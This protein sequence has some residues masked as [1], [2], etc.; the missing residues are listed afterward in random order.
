MVIPTEK[1]LNQRRGCIMQIS[2]DDKKYGVHAESG[3]VVSANKSSV[4]S[5]SGSGDANSMHIKSNHNIETDFWI[6]SKDVERH[7]TFSC[8]IP[9]RNGHRVSIISVDNGKIEKYV[10]VMNFDANRIYYINNH[11]EVAGLF[12]DGKTSLGCLVTAI[13]SCVLPALYL[14]NF[15]PVKVGLGNW[16]L[17][18]IAL[19]FA[20]I[21]VNFV[22]NYKLLA[23]SKTK[24]H[25]EFQRIYGEIESSVWS[26]TAGH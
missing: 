1:Q 14:A 10:A 20:P 24:T 19:F 4:T 21:V 5:V 26:N 16:F 25:H 11:N 22:R 7:Y 23:R 2:V 8:N 12:I 3:I 17:A 13:A 9:M 15:E 18:G 6:K